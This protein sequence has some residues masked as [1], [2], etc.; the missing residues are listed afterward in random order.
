MEYL[1][2][3]LHT[4]ILRKRERKKGRVIEKIGRA[5]YIYIADRIE[6]ERER[7]GGR[8][9]DREREEAKGTRECICACG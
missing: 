5:I 4:S 6:R 9:T 2:R 1:A 3:E 7:K 8:K